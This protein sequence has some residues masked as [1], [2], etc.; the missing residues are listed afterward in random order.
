M[1][2]KDEKDDGKDGKD[3][4]TD[5]WADIEERLEEIR[6]TLRAPWAS[7]PRRVQACDRALRACVEQLA[8]PG[9]LP[10]HGSRLLGLAHEAAQGYLRL[11][12]EPPHLYLEKILFHVVR[13]AAPW[14]GS[15]TWAAA[16]LLRERL[17][18]CRPDGDWAG[19]ARGAFGLLWRAA[20]ALAG[21]ERPREEGRAVLTARIRSL[22]FL[23]L[24]E[25][26]EDSA[27]KS[28]QPPFL[29]SP[30]AQNAAAAAALY[31]AER[32]PCP[33]FLARQL[34]EFLLDALKDE[35][36]R[37]ADFRSSLCFLELTLERCRHLC[38]AR[39]HR[40][41][42]DALRDSREF[43]GAGNSL[44][45][46]LEL[47]EAG[48]QLGKALA[49]GRD[50]AGGVGRALG[51]AGAA[52]AAEFSGRILLVTA[53]SWRFVVGQLG[54]VLRRSTEL[55]LGPQEL[56]GL[57]AFS[58][59][60][61]R[62]LRL[63]LAQVPPDSLREQVMVKQLLFHGLQ[64]FSNAV[65][66]IFQ[67]SQSSEWP[68]LAQVTSSCVQSVTW[69][70]E[71]LQGL[72]EAERGKFLDVTAAVTLRLGQ[73]LQGRKVP[74]AAG[75]VCE[76]LCRA[77]LDTDGYGC[78]GV[79]PERLHRCFRLQV[80]SW[81]SRGRP[82]RALD[83][84]GQWLLAL[85]THC[86]ALGTCSQP[87]QALVALVAE[88]V[89][90]WA[91]IKTEAARQGEEELRLWTLRDAPASRSLGG[92][93]LLLLLLAELR[94]YKSLR[95]PTGA[96]RYNV[97]CDL[98]GLW[99]P[100]GAWA[101]RGTPRPGAAGAPGPAGDPNRSLPRAVALLELGQL[102]C[103]HRF[104]PHTDCSA[105]DALQESLRLL[106][107]LS[108]NSQSRNSQIRDQL[109]DERA[110]ALLWLHICTLEGLME[111]SVS[112]ERRG[113][114]QS[115][116]PD[117]D[118]PRDGT[119]CSPSSEQA[120]S[121]PLDEAFS[122]WRQLLENPGIPQIR[123]PEQ[124][125]SSL[126]LLGALYRIQGKPLQAL[127]SSRLLLSL[128]RRLGDPVGTGSALSQL[129]WALLHLGCPQ[130]AQ[131]N[132]GNSRNSGKEFLKS[133]GCP[134]IP[135]ELGMGDPVGTGSA[136]SQLT[137]AL[138]HLGCP[139]QAQV[140]LEQ[141]ESLLEKE[142]P[143]P[144]AD[145]D[146]RLL[147]H[148]RLLL[149]S[150]LCCL[151]RKAEQAVSLLLQALREPRAPRATRGRFLLQAQAL[152][153]AAAVLELPPALLPAPLRDGL[154]GHA[155]WFPGWSSPKVALLE[156]LKLLRSVLVSL[157]G[158]DILGTARSA[159]PE[160]PSPDTGV[161]TGIWGAWDGN[162]GALGWDFGGPGMGTAPSPWDPIPNPG[163]HPQIPLPAFPAPW[164]V[165]RPL[166]HR[167]QYSQYSQ[168]S[169]RPAV[170]PGP[171]LVHKWQVLGEALSCCRRLVTLLGH[172]EVTC[173]A[174]A[175][176]S[177]GLSLAGHLQ[178][179]RWCTWFLLLQ[180]QLEMQQGELELS[181]SHLQHAQFLLQPQT[182]PKPRRD[183]PRPARILLRK[184][185]PA[186]RNPRHLPSD[187]NPAPG[188]EEE[189]EFLQGPSLDLL[190][191]SVLPE[192]PDALTASPELK[193]GKRK[194]LEFLGH[195]GACPCSF[196]SDAALVALGLRWL[197]A[198]ARLWLLAGQGTPGLALL[199]RVLRRCAGAGT[200]LQ[201]DVW[202]RVGG[203]GPGD[204]DTGTGDAFGDTP[205]N[206]D[207][208]K[209]RD[210]RVGDTF[211]DPPGN[212]DTVRIG[213]NSGDREI[214]GDR[215]VLDPSG[216]RDTIGNGDVPGARDTPG[217]LWD[218][219]RVRGPSGDGDRDIP[220]A[221]DTPG[222]LWDP[223]RVR[224][225]SG[226]GDRDIPG[227]RDTPGDLWDPARVRDP[228][229][230]GDRDIPGVRDTPGDRWDPSR[231]RDPSGDGDRD[232]PGARD[233]PGDLWDPARVR[234]PSGDGDRDIPGVR[235]TPGDLWD[236]A[237]VRGPSGDGDRDIPGDRDTPGDLWDPARVRGPS[238]DGDRDIPGD[239]DTP[240][241]NAP[242]PPGP[243]A[244]LVA[245]G[246]S[247]LALPSPSQSVPVWA[248]ELERALALLT[249]RWPPVAGLGVAVATLLL[250]KAL[251]TL[252]Q[253]AAALGHSVDDVLARCWTP[254]NPEKTPK[255]HPERAPRKG[256][257]AE[258]KAAKTPKG[259]PPKFGE[260]VSLGDS[261]NEV[262]P[263]VL[264]P[265]GVCTPH[266]K[267]GPPQKT[268]LGGPRTPFS[269]FSEE[270]SP[271]GAR[272]RIHR[273]PK[274][275]GRV[276]SRI[277]VTFSDSDPE[278]P[279]IP[280]APPKT[281]PKTSCARKV[282]RPKSPK[283]SPGIGARPRR[284]RPRKELGSPKK[285]G[286]RE[287][288]GI[289]QAENV[290]KEESGIPQTGLE[291]RGRRGNPKVGKTGNSQM[292]KEEKPRNPKV[293]NVEKVEN[294]EMGNLE[295]RRKPKVENLEKTGNSQMENVEKPENLEKRR[296]PKRE[297]P[298]RENLEEMENLEMENLEK[299]R[300]PKMGNPKTEN[301][302]K[303]ENLEKR[304]NPRRENPKTENVEKPEN[305]EKR[306]NP[307]RGSSG[308]KENP[309]NPREKKENRKETGGARSGILEE[310]RNWEFNGI[311]ER[312]PLRAGQEEEE[313]EEEMSFELPP[314]PPGGAE[315]E[316]PASGDKEDPPQPGGS[317]PRP[318]PGVPSLATVRS[319][320]SQALAWI[321]HCPPG[322]LYGRLCQLL[323]LTLGDGDPVATAGLLA[324]SLA[325]TSRHQLLALVH[326][327]TR[328]QRRAAAA[329][330]GGDVSDQLRGLS[331]QEGDPQ[332]SQNSPNSWDSRLAQ[333]Q[334]LFQ[335]SSV[336]LGPA[337]RERFQEQLQKIPHGV[338]VCQLSLGGAGPGV[339]GDALLLTRLERGAEPLS[340]RVD[341][342]RR[343]AP[344][345]EIL[346]EFERIQREQR[347]ANACTERRLWWERRSQLDQRM[348]R[349]IQSLDREVLGCWRALLLPRDPGNS[350]LEEAELSRLLLELR[351]CGW[352]SPR[353][354][355]L[356]V[357]LSGLCPADVRPLAAA[358]CPARPLRARFLLAEALE[359]RREGPGGCAGSLVLLLDKHLQRLPW[360]SSG[361][362]RNVPVTRLPALRF[363]LSYGL[364]QGSGS[365]L[366]RGVDPKNTFYVL[367]PQRDLGGTEE[368]FRGWF[369][370]EPGW[371]GVTGAAPTPQQL[372]EA[373]GERDLYIYAGHGAGA[374][375]LEGQSLAQLRCRAVVLLFGCSS[376]ALSPRGDLEP[377]G[378]VLKYLL[379]GCP[380]V[381]GT[382]W[383]VT[384]RDLDRLTLALLR[385]WLGGG[386]GTPLLPQLA[387]ARAA[388][389]LRALIGAAPVAYGLP[390]CLGGG[391][392]W[393]VP[394]VPE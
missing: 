90:L 346:Q 340:V 361:T 213:D 255:S 197:L 357:L 40:E 222:D 130:Q 362:L 308:K 215:N 101:P 353:P 88:P 342:R 302:E 129:T 46:P 109:L 144:G 163:N 328:K 335:F 253:A 262:P 380:L 167:S 204:G 9:G 47:L 289:N 171:A 246:Y 266:P 194:L 34:Q 286:K 322:S 104:A 244:E 51:R 251:A 45:A 80:E 189:E 385:G 347:E 338:T 367:N 301:V 281:T 381:L 59:G 317:G 169:Q 332:N 256:R 390:V 239:R 155:L 233:T 288:T 376:A 344:L 394:S 219:A 368:R 252:G 107:S 112:R 6:D 16:E 250:T 363:L 138:L 139:Q 142:D 161:G 203:L 300:N 118:R 304:R 183:P 216:N 331:L 17:R 156:A 247:T 27:P 159:A 175:F 119:H 264:R 42:L 208:I 98:L 71:G 295:K 115:P 273:A 7:Q 125:V 272:G 359:R 176:C 184:G 76:P 287:K 309:P 214:L 87:S 306:R 74:E 333:L 355:L 70:V 389:R 25:S 106:E 4:S 337:E 188:A 68:E 84:L 279:Q 69:M 93:A 211:G 53:E 260:V 205:G 370:S 61:G 12:P 152:R 354:A 60:H 282:Q 21:P 336:G 122:L 26:R 113:R 54:E 179:P 91:R 15:P 263:V 65:H 30:A 350:P 52:L 382:L 352:D 14:A 67:R 32:A 275:P 127:G 136:L 103:S 170:S 81:R 299:R 323:A 377:T 29:T 148:E 366:S 294:S 191:P 393:G 320:L 96:E 365:V 134:E 291:K 151:Q 202:G 236:P 241:D 164:C 135:G 89:A 185:H 36:P 379:A 28:F 140:F 157:M 326:A 199:R 343:Q 258:T 226:D 146:L 249:S 392:S 207:N 58:Q 173:R 307:R 225:P 270:P 276:K 283:N 182:A 102:L 1:D 120:L 100:R 321:G 195:P 372:H 209:D 391:G 201:R 180:S 375:L 150:H 303:P 325:V 10:A 237:R 293:K 360:E 158:S 348:Q 271:P 177:E 224:D 13:N 267:S 254:K 50:G 181:Q 261:D 141:L 220:G 108:R 327:R 187:P 35:T 339:L 229:G 57:C 238:G 245:L 78:P 131:V 73:A 117:G 384:D 371:R 386:P 63:L 20:A 178:A 227:A 165:P 111:K 268:L 153:V 18:R 192:Q 341:T 79:T 196:C 369:Q 133:W 198:Q 218:P 345:S 206:G 257:S 86:Q 297:N 39:R 364:T 95:G 24:L 172:C 334:E 358:L 278:E 186:T 383:D 132:L 41:A 329:A 378:T 310:K 324:E 62:V 217:D 230:D 296:N 298:K 92:D 99:D 231:V 290:G 5:S 149:R 48:I 154:R 168:R 243:L 265:G 22:R 160:E 110:Q 44:G 356:Q 94:A 23:L 311:E 312:D 11:V 210:R 318:Q 33:L 123:S 43:L 242:C 77:L 351:E 305:Q 284:G 19:V 2:G 292:G 193:P 259:K 269:I 200:R 162:L 319:L 143:G 72:P 277:R 37:P 97:L 66:E 49:K 388:P 85:G 285:R 240:G 221:R 190:A 223:A 349:L 75:A 280:P 8:R 374:R 387:Q 64:L 316:I 114:L 83:A 313:E 174:R 121:K 126:Q 116:E 235:D 56:P 274:M 147:R 124:T 128:C 145:A 82:R 228:S 314:M 105:L 315:E 248:E 166:S 373:L 137:W 234:D 232:I 330:A 55:P 31:Q 38:K 212:G 3:G